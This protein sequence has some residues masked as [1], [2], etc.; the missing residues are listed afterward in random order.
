MSKR[1]LSGG[2]MTDTTID[3]N[4]IR[5]SQ[6]RDVD[7]YACGFPCTPFS[8]K[9][10]Q[11]GW[12]DANSKPF[13]VAAKTI[14]TLRPKAVVLENVMGIT[15]QGGLDKVMSVL[16]V[17]RGYVSTSLV[18]LSNLD[19][20]IPQHRPR[21]YI[22]MI[23]S[24]CVKGHLNEDMLNESLNGLLSLLKKPSV[25]WPRFLERVGLPLVRGASASSVA[26]L[27]NRARLCK[28]GA[29]GA[30][31]SHSCK[32]RLCA[33]HQRKAGLA[34]RWRALHQAH[35]RKPVVRAAR[36]SMLKR[37]QTIRTLACLLLGQRRVG[38]ETHTR[39]MQGCRGS[40]M[41]GVAWPPR[42]RLDCLR[43][44]RFLMLGIIEERP[45][46]EDVADLL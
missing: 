15:R 21:V 22:V 14:A 42:L 43:S 23:R 19:F 5:V 31:S 3:G 29:K 41:W 32:C 28:C 18:N 11:L 12:D 17:I 38:S 2:T 1:V 35:R 24:D 13:W 33:G 10:K 4:S 34:C 26:D 25:R 30:C 46:P 16:N 7:L 36:V 45:G 40:M 39:G 37:W 8:T 20:G 27:Q 44:A 6:D 9:G